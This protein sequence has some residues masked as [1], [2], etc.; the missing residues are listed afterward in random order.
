[1]NLALLYSLTAGQKLDKIYTNE[2]YYPLP[3]KNYI[4]IQPY[5]RPS[6]NF[7]YFSEVIDL[8]YLVLEKLNLKI[9]QVGAKDEP[10]LNYC[11]HTQ[12]TTNW[13]QL[14]YIISKA[15][16]VLTID[17]ISAHLAGHYNIP[18][19]DIVSNNFKECV[20]PYFGD[21]SKQIILEP[22]RTKQN[23]SFMLD[24]GLIKQVDQ[25]KPETVA[26]SVLQLLNVSERINLQTINIGPL[27]KQIEFNCILNQIVQPN[28]L[29]Q[30][31]FLTLRYDL[32][33]KE[34]FLYHQASLSKVVIWTNKKL[35]ID[36][37]KQLKP[38]I[39]NIIYNI[40][41]E[42]SSTSLSFIKSIRK[43]GLN[44]ALVTEKKDEELNDE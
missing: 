4:V 3:F 17:S 2:K 11:Y 24:E 16:L 6:K 10:P 1:M 42:E 41:L 28:F 35:N 30:N 33:G 31:G 25:I 8:I 21:K 18:L 7:N 9:I 37:L 36:I 14:Q 12:G 27:F 13:G 15:K 38:N 22:D 34:E 44:F 26:N 29:N 39:V 19:V 23:P 32:E 5:S 40:D 43:L 20:A